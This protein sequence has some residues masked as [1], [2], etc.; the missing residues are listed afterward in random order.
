MSGEQEPVASPALTQFEQIY[1]SNVGVVTAY[2]ALRCAEPQTVADLTSETFVR[3]IGAFES[4]DPRRGAP[5]AWLFG[6]AGHVYARHCEQAASGRVV[7]ARLA[8]RRP[9]DG[10]EIEELAAR[11]DAER[12]GRAL[13]ERCAE[14]PELERGGRARRPRWALA[15]GGRRGARGLTRGAAQAAVPGAIPAEKGARP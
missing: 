14:L 9:L 2:F 5:R 13:I 1:L 6:I 4:F 10:D 15:Q 11:I 12:A 7:V 3:A 8:H